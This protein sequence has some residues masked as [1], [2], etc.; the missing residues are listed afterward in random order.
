MSL[1]RPAIRQ[2]SLPKPVSPGYWW[3]RTTYIA[4]MRGRIDS[5]TTHWTIVLVTVWHGDPLLEWGANPERWDVF[6][7]RMVRSN[8]VAEWV[9]PIPPPS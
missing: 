3:L 1:A 6:V 4:K 2:A 5:H 9:G 8:A 7:A